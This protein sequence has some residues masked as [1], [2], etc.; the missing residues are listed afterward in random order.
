MTSAKHV[1]TQFS[2]YQWRSRTKAEAEAGHAA[3]VEVVTRQ[4]QLLAQARKIVLGY[5]LK[6]KATER[7]QG[8]SVHHRNRGTMTKK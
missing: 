7:E 2:I 4:V 5:T 6:R 1:V 3:A 8:H